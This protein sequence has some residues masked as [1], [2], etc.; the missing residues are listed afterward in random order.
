MLCPF[1]LNFKNRNLKKNM[2]WN[3]TILTEKHS[4]KWRNFSLALSYTQ[5]QTLTG[6]GEGETD[7]WMIFSR[8]RSREGLSGFSGLGS[9]TMAFSCLSF[10]SLTQSLFCISSWVAATR[11]SYSDPQQ[12]TV[13]FVSL[14]KHTAPPTLFLENDSS[15]LLPEINRHHQSSATSTEMQNI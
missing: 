1:V 13:Y 6:T 4:S 11:R 7:L 10:S 12:V 14:H 2:A 8:S 15:L 5:L 9:V 3:K